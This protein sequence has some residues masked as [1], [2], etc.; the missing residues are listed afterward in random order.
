MTR[1]QRASEDTEGEAPLCVVWRTSLNPLCPL[2]SFV[3]L[4]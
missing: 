1:T 4:A 2:F 3:T